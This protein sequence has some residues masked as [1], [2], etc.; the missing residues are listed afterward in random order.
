[1]DGAK[2]VEKKN[3]R[4]KMSKPTL[5]LSGNDGNA[6]AILGAAK[7]AGKKAGWSKQQLS[8]FQIEATSGDYDNVLQTCMKHFEVE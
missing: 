6:F 3:R 2:A 5:Q 7:K 4:L 8:D 1:V